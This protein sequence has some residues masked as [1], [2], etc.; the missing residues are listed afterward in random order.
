M[1]LRVSKVV[2]ICCNR[3]L[4]NLSIARRCTRATECFDGLYLLSSKL[5][6]KKRSNCLSLF[7]HLLVHLEIPIPLSSGRCMN[8]QWLTEFSSLKHGWFDRQNVSLTRIWPRNRIDSRTLRIERSLG[9][10]GT[11]GP[12][13][14]RTR[15]PKEEKC[16]QNTKSKQ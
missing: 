2:S 11:I 13:P 4:Q 5:Q 16:I 1:L 9:F 7:E 3:T 15:L 12:I 10:A 14:E 6:T 8:K